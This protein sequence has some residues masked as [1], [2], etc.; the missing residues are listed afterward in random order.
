MVLVFGRG[1]RWVGIIDGIHVLCKTLSVHEL[2]SIILMWSCDLR[3]CVCAAGS[4]TTSLTS[5]ELQLLTSSC[6]KL[7]TVQR[8]V[9]NPGLE[10]P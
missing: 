4:K 1:F 9:L 5:V 8:A 3:V 6:M 7:Q 2:L 10:G